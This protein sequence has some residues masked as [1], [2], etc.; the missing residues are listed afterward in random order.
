MRQP[1]FDEM[2]EEFMSS[3]Q[4]P[5]EGQASPTAQVT[6]DSMGLGRTPGQRG[7]EIMAGIRAETM[8]SPI[9]IALSRWS[10]RIVV[11]F[12]RG[13]SRNRSQGILNFMPV[14]TGG[15]TA[16]IKEAIGE[17]KGSLLLVDIAAG[18]S[19][20][21]VELAQAYPNAEVIEIDLPDV[22]AEK[23]KRLERAQNF[24]V[25]ANLHW[26]AADMGIKPL[27]EVLEGRTA[28][29]ISAEGLTPYFP[30]PDLVK[31][32]R[33]IHD[34]LKPG[35]TL[36]CDMAWR[37]GIRQ[38]QEVSS[39]LSRQAGNFLGAMD[40]QE[41]ARGIFAEAGYSEVNIY[42]PSEVAQKYN[43]PQPVLDLQLLVTARKKA[44]VAEQKSAEP[45]SV[46]TE[47]TAPN[48]GQT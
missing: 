21:G 3:E 13:L 30:P 46:K 19:P 48:Q 11:R 27:S 16:L 38:T 4:S 31:I 28:H 14:R 6:P 12:M 9:T 41:Q 47:D 10:G 40:S 33:Q 5:P 7:A 1:L 8:P 17:Q 23:K 22:I 43:L 26:R 35:G 36:V 32:V 20:R 34:S 25:P 42:L 37:E 29:I 2:K 39:F 24:K 45:G 18:F 44:A 15:I